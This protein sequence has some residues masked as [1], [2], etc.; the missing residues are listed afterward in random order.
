MRRRKK[1]FKITGDL[2]FIINK[3]ECGNFVGEKIPNLSLKNNEKVFK[4][5]AANTSANVGKS[6]G[7][8]LIYYLAKD[9]FEIYLLTV[10]SKKDTINLTNNEIKNLIKNYC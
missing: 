4:V 9:N 2:D 1:Y 3:L 6:N 5:R 8:R 10:Y 7:F